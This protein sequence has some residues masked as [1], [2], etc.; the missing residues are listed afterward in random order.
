MSFQK[1]ITETGIDHISL[2]YLNMDLDM[3]FNLI[4]LRSISNNKI[5]S[6]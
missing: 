6:V 5:K 2:V 4:Y 3:K 1:S